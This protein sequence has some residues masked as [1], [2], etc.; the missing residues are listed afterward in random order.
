MEAGGSPLLP[1]FFSFVLRAKLPSSTRAI[2]I[3]PAEKNGFSHFP[4]M[5][6]PFKKETTAVFPVAYRWRKK[7]VSPCPD[8]ETDRGG[9]IVD[10]EDRGLERKYFNNAAG[11][12]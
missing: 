12:G 2:E 5:Q 8:T 11:L 1:P 4:I 9:G 3:E 6:I 7:G 10:R